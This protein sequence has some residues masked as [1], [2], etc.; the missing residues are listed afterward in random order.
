MAGGAAEAQYL[1]FSTKSAAAAA[2]KLRQFLALMP[3]DQLEAAQQQ[4]ATS[5]F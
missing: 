5:P 3:A 1:D 2:G 4:L